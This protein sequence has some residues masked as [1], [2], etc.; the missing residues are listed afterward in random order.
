MGRRRLGGKRKVQYVECMKCCKRFD[1]WTD[2]TAYER[3]PV[4]PAFGTRVEVKIRF[5]GRQRDFF[6]SKVYR[7]NEF[8]HECGG[9]LKRIDIPDPVRKVV[10]AGGIS[11]KLECGHRQHART[12]MFGYTNATRRACRQCGEEARLEA[13]RSGRF[14]AWELGLS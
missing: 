4:K 10:D 9:K 13:V 5:I 2:G 3:T 11:E 1:F 6:E 14:Q 8:L 12:D 7:L